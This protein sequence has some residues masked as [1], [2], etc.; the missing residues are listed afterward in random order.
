MAK[1]VSRSQNS[2]LTRFLKYLEHQKWYLATSNMAKRVVIEKSHP[3]WA[4]LIGIS[5]PFQL[6]LWLAIALA[7]VTWHVRRVLRY[8]LPKN[9]HLSFSPLEWR[10]VHTFRC[11]KRCTFRNSSH[12]S[13]CQMAWLTGDR[14]S[15]ANDGISGC[16][17]LSRRNI[18][19]MNQI[20][21]KNY[22]K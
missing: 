20:N 1:R 8:S 5:Q 19:K 2:N 10:W 7:T 15:K 14:S 18:E 6:T 13:H 16:T 22:W 4:G 17:V 9:L 12:S 3:A 11:Q 21:T